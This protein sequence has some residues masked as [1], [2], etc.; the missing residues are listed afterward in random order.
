MS[1]RLVALRAAG[2]DKCIAEFTGTA[3]GP[4][5]V[6]FTVVRDGGITTASSSPDVFRDFD[7]SAEDQRRLVAAVAVFCEVAGR[8]A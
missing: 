3:N 7:G 5:A 6:E 8:E 1:L 2:P 4:L